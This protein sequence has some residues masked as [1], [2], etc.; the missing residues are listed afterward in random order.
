M[1]NVVL[2]LVRRLKELNVG[3]F[4]KWT[5]PTPPICKI[6][7]VLLC[8]NCLGF[9][10]F[11]LESVE[12]FQDSTYYLH[13]SSIRSVVEKVN[14][15]PKPTHFAWKTGANIML[16]PWENVGNIAVLVIWLSLAH[17]GSSLT[18]CLAIFSQ[19][20]GSLIQPII[21]KSYLVNILVMKYFRASQCS[22]EVD[23][24]AVC[25]P[26]DPLSTLI[27]NMIRYGLAPPAS[28]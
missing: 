26:K 25:A 9:D 6:S 23:I 19:S 11:L 2:S 18:H 17:A 22:A 5:D 8:N 13:E 21:R 28:V 10:V 3:S 20:S 24:Q 12:I 4:K 7:T 16:W 27:L 1:K 15:V 14:T